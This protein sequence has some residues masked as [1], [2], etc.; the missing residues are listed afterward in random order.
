M[1]SFVVSGSW[2]V[3]VERDLPWPVGERRRRLLRGFND[4]HV[5]H[6]VGS[7]KYTFAACRDV[8][9]L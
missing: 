3:L 6:K 4:S 9:N 5:K 8:S 2:S 7:T 1:K